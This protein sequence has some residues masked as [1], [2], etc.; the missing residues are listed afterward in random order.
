[1]G[2]LSKIILHEGQMISD[3]PLINNYMI[4]LTT[5]LIQTGSSLPQE[6]TTNL[7]LFCNILA[8]YKMKEKAQDS[9]KFPYSL[10]MSRSH[11]AYPCDKSVTITNI[12]LN[13]L[14][15]LDYEDAVVAGRMLL[16]K[17]IEQIHLN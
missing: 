14:W 2:R 7:Q 12:L 4:L 5:I 17:F 9:K 15:F 10:K 6:C 13:L 3:F 8:S 16:K 11:M 1:M